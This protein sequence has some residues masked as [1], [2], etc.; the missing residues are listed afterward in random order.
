M[1]RFLVL[2]LLGCALLDGF[3]GHRK[4]AAATPKALN[5]WVHD[6]DFPNQIYQYSVSTTGNLTLTGG[7]L[8]TQNS[9]A[10]CTGDCQTMAYSN[11]RKLLFT[12]GGLGISVTDLSA[13]APALVSGS[14]FGGAPFIGVAVVEKGKNTYVYASQNESGQLFG[15]RVTAAKTLEALPGSP[16]PAGITPIGMSAAKD[17]LFVAREVEKSIGAYKI[18]ADGTPVAA[19]GSPSSLPD[20]I[21]VYNVDVDPD[22]KFVYIGD[23]A[24][25]QVYGFKVAPRTAALSPLPGSPFSVGTSEICSGLAFASRR[26]LLALN[27]GG[28]TN[29]IQALRKAANGALTALGS[30]QNSVDASPRT[31]AVD[32]LGRYV[33]FADDRTDSV[34]TFTLNK[35]S[36]QLSPASQVS[37]TLAHATAALFVQR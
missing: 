16:Y 8:D 27:D 14:P 26:L 13:S 35:Q 2:V 32:P 7:P 24:G 4:P 30:A 37:Q 34:R 18:A 15:F 29:S 23:C 3:L 9:T 11:R 1:R 36:G 5:L 20:T 22:G 19:P 25:P 6:S 17:L 21:D 28:P 33:A 10:V 12:S 31:A